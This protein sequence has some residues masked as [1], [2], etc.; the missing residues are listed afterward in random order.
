V[1]TF[2]KGVFGF[3]LDREVGSGVLTQPNITIPAGYR[4]FAVNMSNQRHWAPGVQRYIADCLA[5]QDG[6]RG[7]DFNMRWTGSM[8]ADIQR[9]LIAAG[10]SCI[11]GTR[12]SRTVRASCG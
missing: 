3:T 9:I 12:G 10:S 5:G 11:P 7:Q 6:P 2:G 4:E 1:L 8:L